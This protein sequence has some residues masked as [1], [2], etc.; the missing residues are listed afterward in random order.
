MSEETQTPTVAPE[1]VTEGA[2]MLLPA[3]TVPSELMHQF[4][5][6]ATAAKAGNVST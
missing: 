3:N 2:I 5:P 4:T 1:N 6:T